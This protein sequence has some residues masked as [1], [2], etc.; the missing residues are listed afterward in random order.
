MSLY[1]SEDKNG[2]KFMVFMMN[3]ESLF[4]KHD[5]NREVW[6]VCN[7]LRNKFFM[8]KIDMEF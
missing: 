2:G 8:F 3:L 7:E 5:V 6:D 4:A 1:Y